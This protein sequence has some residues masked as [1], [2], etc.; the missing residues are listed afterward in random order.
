MDPHLNASGHTSQQPY[1]LD[2]VQ[3][4]QA[5]A[6]AVDT[7]SSSELGR[8]AQDLGTKIT[9]WHDKVTQ[10]LNQWLSDAQDME[11]A[12]SSFTDTAQSVVKQLRA[13]IQAYQKYPGHVKFTQSQNQRMLDMMSELGVPPSQIQGGESRFKRI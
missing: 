1:S 3:G 11:N 10:S 12:L 13:M 4:T 6:Q 2:A 8:V 7:S 5:D 9:E